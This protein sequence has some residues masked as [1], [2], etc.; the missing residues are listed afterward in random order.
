LE[1]KKKHWPSRRSTRIGGIAPFE[2]F[3][4]VVGP[5]AFRGGRS[6]EYSFTV[7]RANAEYCS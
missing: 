4:V 5:K 1:S 2:Y 6:E 3:R 7:H